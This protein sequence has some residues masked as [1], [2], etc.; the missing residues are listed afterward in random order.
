MND[1]PNTKTT[2]HA[3]TRDN[4]DDGEMRI[5]SSN[6][7]QLCSMCVSP[8]CFF[9]L[10]PLPLSYHVSWLI[11]FYMHVLKPSLSLNH[12]LS[13]LLCCC[14]MVKQTVE[15][16]KDEKLAINLPTRRGSEMVGSGE[17]E[18][19]WWRW[20][21]P[22]STSSKTISPTDNER[23]GGDGGNLH[24]SKL[25]VSFTVS[26]PHYNHHHLSRFLFSFSLPCVFYLSPLLPSSVMSG[27]DSSI[28][29]QVMYEESD[30]LNGSNG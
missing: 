2:C 22:T 9:S 3:M 17:R 25:N 6:R 21:S 16:S 30:V 27:Y 1:H 12:S 26:I 15:E 23:G 24:K 5:F 4:D 7:W 28:Y 19:W 13:T 10:I 18:G 29:F 14:L 8:F 11:V 20:W